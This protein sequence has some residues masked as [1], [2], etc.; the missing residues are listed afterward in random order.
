MDIM[1]AKTSYRKFW[2]TSAHRGM[3]EGVLKENTLA[4]FYNAYLNGADMLE[5]DARMTRDGVLVCNHNATAVGFDPARGEVA[6]YAVAETD[7]DVICSLILSE[8]EKWGTQRV[9]TLDEALHLAYHTGLIL[10]IDM[11]NGSL[12][13]DEIVDAVLR[14]GMRGRVST[15][16]TVRVRIRC[17]RSFPATPTPGSSTHPPTTQRKDCPAFRITA[18]G[19]L[20]TRGI[21][22]QKIHKRYVHPAVCWH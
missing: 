20:P 9:P 11:K 7:A 2:L 5:T 17:R 1:T 14:N 22:R 3:V 16:Q 15:P 10:N 6:E 13:A 18:A 19:V 21:S 8:D 12:Y 4:A